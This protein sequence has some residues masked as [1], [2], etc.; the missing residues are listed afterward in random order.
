LTSAPA[1]P[2]PEPL[3]LGTAGDEI[4]MEGPFE[5]GFFTP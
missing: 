3:G 4:A 2:L 5:A 1:G